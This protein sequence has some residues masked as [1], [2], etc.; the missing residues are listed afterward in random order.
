[1]TP[2]R[3][4]PRIAPAAVLLALL[5]LPLGAQVPAGEDLPVVE[6]TLDNGMRILVLPRRASPTVSFV[7]RYGVGSVHEHLGNTGIAHLLEHM[8]FK[9][10]TTVGTRNPEAERELFR[11]MDQIQDSI[12]RE[13]AERPRPNQ[14]RLRALEDSM[15]VLRER[16]RTYV[17]SNEFDEILTENGARNLNATTGHESTTYYVQLA[18]NRAKLW[19]VLEADRMANPV[20]REFYTERDV[21]AEE[22][23]TRIDNSP[24]GRMHE[25]HLGAAFQAHP[26][27]VP[28]IGYMSDIQNLTREQ[29]RRYYEDFYGARNAVVAVVGDV[30]T[31]SILTWA[32]QYLGRIRPG[33]RP[34]PVLTEEPEQRGER[35]H[36]V[37]FDAEAQIQMSW[38][39]VDVFHPDRP[40]LLMLSSILTGGRTSRLQRRMVQ[41]ERVASFVSS[42][43]GPGELYPGLFTVQA[44]PRGSHTTDEIERIVYEEIDSLKEVPPDPVE[45]QRVRN[46]L[47][48][49]RI[50]RLESNFGLALQLAGSA[51]LFGDWRTTFR[52]T[53]RLQEVEPRDVR[54]VALRYFDR[55]NRTVTVLVPEEEELAR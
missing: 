34:D 11:R 27:G 55:Q 51:S 29:A 26:Y 22:R 41:E 43:V 3:I 13:K 54:R 1:M 24:V 39:V 38:H 28:S 48:A 25:E 19:F 21:V 52:F 49:S 2:D 14:V 5:A 20:F 7:V 40:A 12:L 8:L 16:A 17:V 37:V 44:F 47:E 53:D 35:R 42:S 4:P 33:R 18:A 31:D 10:T 15:D 46:Q 32:E 36:E 9:G 6:D 50:R 30:E 45:L 23:R